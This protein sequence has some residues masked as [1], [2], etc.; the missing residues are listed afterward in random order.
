MELPEP[1]GIGPRTAPNR[2]LFGPHEPT[3]AGTGPS[4]NATPP[5]TR[6]GRGRRRHHRDRGGVGPPVVLALRA[7]TAGCGMR[8]GWKAVA[9]ACATHGSLMLGGNRP[10]GG[11]GSSAFHQRELWAPSEVPEVNSREMP[12]VMETADIAAVVAGFG[13]AAALA[14]AGVGGGRDQR[15]PAQPGAPV[16]V[17]T[18]EH[19]RRRLRRRQTALCPRGA[20]R[21]PLA[22]ARTPWS[23]WLVL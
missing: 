21:G 9:E 17:R 10:R 14:T 1:P 19:A 2:V 12:K 20:R 18:D 16:P 6:G 3:W 15:R 11:Q 8:P 23:G 5:T 13:E 4:A 7:G 22:L